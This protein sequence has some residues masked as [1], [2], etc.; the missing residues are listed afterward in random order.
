MYS[1]IKT[2]Y[3]TVSKKYAFENL[4]ITYDGS[5]PGGFECVSKP[6]EYSK[7]A[8]TLN[9]F[10]KLMGDE[11]CYVDYRCGLHIHIGIQHLNDDDLGIKENKTYLSGKNYVKAMLVAKGLYNILTLA[12]PKSR[13]NNHFCKKNKGPRVS[14][15][16]ASEDKLL[17]ALSQYYGYNFKYGLSP[18]PSSKA[19]SFGSRYYWLNLHSLAFHGTIENRLPAGTAEKKDIEGWCLI[20]KQILEFILEGSISDFR[21]KEKYIE[22]LFIGFLGKAE[23]NYLKGNIIKHNPCAKELEYF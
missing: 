7:M 11:K 6:F 5:V 22:E 1:G 13:W 8:N 19:P 15:M 14:H 16:G 10:E 4:E 12:N 3:R 21:K 17:E 20:T 9:E 2:D 23:K 18:L